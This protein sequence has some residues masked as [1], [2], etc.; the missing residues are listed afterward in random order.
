MGLNSRYYSLHFDRK[1]SLSIRFQKHNW[2]QTIGTE[3][4]RSTIVC[5]YTKTKLYGDSIQNQLQHRTAV[6]ISGK[7]GDLLD[8]RSIKLSPQMK[9]WKSGYV[10]KSNVFSFAY[11]W[12]NIE[13]GRL[14]KFPWLW[15][16]NLKG[17]VTRIL[18]GCDQNGYSKIWWDT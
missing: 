12:L 7:E 5:Q 4:L 17:L 11:S 2:L 18:H 6:K 10:Q 3:L 1:S 13:I 9:C 16:L 15:K 8:K 14:G